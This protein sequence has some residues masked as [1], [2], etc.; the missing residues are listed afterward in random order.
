MYFVIILT[1]VLNFT[2]RCGC[3]SLSRTI[4]NDT[5]FFHAKFPAPASKL[6]TFEYTVTFPFH[7]E[8]VNLFFYTTDT[9]VN[10]E[11][12]CSVRT[13]DQV[14]YNHMHQEFRLHHKACP[15]SYSN[16][17]CKQSRSIQDYMPR[18]F[19]FSFGFYCKDKL[20]KSLKGLKYNVT[21]HL[22]SNETK[23][24]NM[25]ND[26]TF[27]SNYYRQVSFPNL[28]DHTYQKDAAKLFHTLFPNEFIIDNIFTCYP[29]FLKA[30]CY[31]FFPRC[32]STAK[33]FIVP[34]RE[35]WEE[36]RE[37]CFSEP[38]STSL[39][40]NLL[41]NILS[42]T[43]NLPLY[44]FSTKTFD[45]KYLPSRLQDNIQ[46]YYEE[47]ICKSP[48]N[49]TG[50]VIVKGLHQNG[51]YIGG[52][53]VEYSCIDHSKQIVGNN[54][55]RCLYNTSWSD[56][57]VCRDK[58]S[59]NNLLKILLPTLF[60]LIWCIII[61]VIIVYI[62]RRRRRNNL[63]NV[64]LRRRREFDA[65]VCYDFDENNDYAMGTL[66]PE[67]E[68]NQDPPFKL[69][70]HVRDFD[71]GLRIFDNIQNAIE[72]SNSAILVMSQA[73]VNSIW[74]K[75][76]FERCYIEN[77]SDPAFQLFVIM[78]QPADT[79]EQLSESMKTFLTQRTYLQRD[80][81][82]LIQKIAAYLTE[83]KKP[84]DDE[85]N[86]NDADNTENDANNPINAN[87][88]N[89]VRYHAHNNVDIVDNDDADGARNDAGNGNFGYNM[90]IQ[91][92]DVENV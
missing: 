24:S 50:A 55:V 10:I 81:P 79:L 64:I 67:F 92:A 63:R 9:H 13:Y 73:F 83:V 29:Y 16:V 19:G 60:L 47:V 58:H 7:L 52:S 35:T 76:E 5:H 37:A 33:S 30:V 43:P 71:P 90:T 38:Q 85:N 82:N 28:I 87:D 26:L 31:L 75:E 72:S 17:H 8:Y 65:Y 22:Q 12:E 62:H 44:Y 14:M 70:I 41:P 27:C 39:L 74:C 36:L 45:Y 91:L 77:M 46:C 84:D 54:T 34:C 11:E 68:G 21:I 78:M 20:R 4:T 61:A 56:P 42:P 40:E 2:R 25:S 49:V 88:N 1:F 15:D 32:N 53:E 51:S 57:P 6:A 18:H 89:M 86:D 23:C 3:L 48:P 66:L 59:N 80:D 69:C